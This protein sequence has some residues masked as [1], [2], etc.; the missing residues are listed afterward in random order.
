MMLKF[1]RTTAAA[2]AVAV[3]TMGYSAP[4]FAQGV[5][6]TDVQSIAQQIQQLKHMLQDMGIQNQQLDALLKQ[7]GELEK[8]LTQLEQMYAAL[9]GKGSFKD[10]VM[11]GRLDGVLD[12]QMVSVLQT[13]RSAQGGDWSGLSGSASAAMTKSAKDSLTNA[14]LPPAAVEKMAKSGDPQAGRIATQATTSAV[15]SAAAENAHAEAGQGIERI[16]VLSGEIPNQTTMKEAIDLNTRMTAELT[17][18]V[19]KNTEMLAVQTV[20][21][22]NAGVVDAATIAAEKQFMDFTLPDMGK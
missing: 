11:G 19:I 3:A 10:I 8:Q 14:G 13:I 6:T 17:L 16:K 12:P 21:A 9:T 4:L 5:P 15:V 18:Q 2:V 1:F 20:G 22:G 7:V